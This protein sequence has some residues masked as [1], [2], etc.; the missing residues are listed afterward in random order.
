MEKGGVGVLGRP[1][2]V[3]GH[4]HLSQTLREKS[5][6]H[7]TGDS[8]KTRDVTAIDPRMVPLIVWGLRNFQNALWKS[9]ILLPTETFCKDSTVCTCKKGITMQALR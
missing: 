9:T 6:Q 2:V 3:T 1:A 5:K 7:T 8:I 4:S